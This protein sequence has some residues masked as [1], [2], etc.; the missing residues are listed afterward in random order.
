LIDRPLVVDGLGVDD[1]DVRFTSKPTVVSG[2]VRD[3]GLRIVPDAAVVVFPEDHGLRT[4]FGAKPQRVRTERAVSGRYTF[5]GLPPGDYF[6]VALDDALMDPWPDP[7]FLATLVPK[8]SRIS[9]RSGE[10]KTL[11][12]TAK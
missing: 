10:R 1:L 2:V 5:L 11:D 6:V 7:S 8:A 9:I 12:L 3:A 4:T